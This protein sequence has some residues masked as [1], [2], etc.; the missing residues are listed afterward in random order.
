MCVEGASNAL[1]SVSLQLIS[2]QSRPT[3]AVFKF[4]ACEQ[5]QLLNIAACVTL[6]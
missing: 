3:I 2:D 5:I 1:T 6:N 4:Q